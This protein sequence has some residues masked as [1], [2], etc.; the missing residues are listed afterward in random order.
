MNPKER[1][2]QQLNVIVD[3]LRNFSQIPDDHFNELFRVSWLRKAICDPQVQAREIKSIDS[4]YSIESTVHHNIKGINWSLDRPLALLGPLIGTN[5]CRINRDKIKILIIGPRHESEV[6]LYYGFGFRPENVYA[7]DLISYSDLIEIGD[8]H[9][10]PYADN[11]FDIVVC[12]W[13]IAY[14]SDQNK[15]ISEMIRVVKDT[16]LIAIGMDQTATTREAR[17]QRAK[18]NKDKLGYTLVPGGHPSPQPL[19][20]LFGNT[21][22]HILFNNFTNEIQDKTNNGC[23]YNC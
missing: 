5:E 3:T 1:F 20:D 10:L 7:I 18:E 19:L 9:E 11:S 12:G 4:K 15:A 14:S 21:I 23:K 8:M 16:G 2:K 13:V 17:E 6:Y 22:S